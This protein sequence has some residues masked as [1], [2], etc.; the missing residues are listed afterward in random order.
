MSDILR[1]TNHPVWTYA[2][3][4]LFDF[5]IFFFHH[6]NIIGQITFILCGEQ[7]RTQDDYELRN[8]PAAGL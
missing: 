5:L 7:T 1:L 4:F 2:Y 6:I 8:K 3:D